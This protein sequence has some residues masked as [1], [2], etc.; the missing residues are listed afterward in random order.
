MYKNTL[1]IVGG[2]LSA[3]GLGA[4]ILS[5][6]VVMNTTSLSWILQVSASV[7]GGLGLFY[8]SKLDL[9]KYWTK[10]NTNKTVQT[11]YYSN[12]KNLDEIA[13][14]FKENNDKD[15]LDK[16]KLLHDLLFQ[17]EYLD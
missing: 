3:Y 2:L 12:S 16:C 5:K 7:L 9:T 8:L 11:D 17:R 15:G 6:F 13:R 1:K 10:S 14:S 4:V